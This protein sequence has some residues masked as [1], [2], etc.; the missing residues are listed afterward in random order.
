MKFTYTV[1]YVQTKIEKCLEGFSCYCKVKS[2][3]KLTQKVFRKTQ[4]L[5]II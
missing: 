3:A 4:G 5:I 1:L 2:F